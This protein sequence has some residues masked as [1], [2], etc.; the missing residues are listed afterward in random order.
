[1][2][3]SLSLSLSPPLRRQ[4]C[5]ALLLAVATLNQ[6]LAISPDDPDYEAKKAAF[7]YKRVDEDA[8]PSLG[9]KMGEIRFFVPPVRTPLPALVPGR[10]SL[11]RPAALRSPWACPPVSV[12][13]V[14][15]HVLFV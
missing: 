9:F 6:V 12:R 11:R 10:Q 15:S 14:R 4:T 7:P 3:C 8:E 1:M 5:F 13:C 2:T